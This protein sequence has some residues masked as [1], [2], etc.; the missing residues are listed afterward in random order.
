MFFI[1]QFLVRRKEEAKPISNHI[2]MQGT[3][4]AYLLQR[5]TGIAQTYG[6]EG[7]STAVHFITGYPDTLKQ[8]IGD[9]F[10][11]NA[12]SYAI[13]YDGDL[14]LYAP[15]EA[16]WNFALSTIEFLLRDGE[17]G[18]LTLFDYPD[19]ETRGYRVFLPHKDD[20]ETFRHV[21]DFLVQYKYNTIML[22]IG[23]AMEYKR[24]PEINA[25]WVEFCKDMKR[26]SGR[27]HEIQHKTYPW[28]KNAIHVDNGG[29]DYLTQEQVKELVSYCRERFLEVI[30]E[31]PT[32]SH[33]DYLLLAHPELRERDNDDYADTYCPSN[34]ESYKL[35]FDVLDE[36]IDVMQPKRINIGHDEAYTFSI[37][38]T[39]KDQIPYKLYAQDIIKIHEYLNQKGIA[40]MM[41][42]EK[43][44]DAKN[45]SG[46]SIGGG[47][48]KVK[49]PETGME[50]IYI[51]GLSDCASLLPKDITMMHWYH[52]FDENYDHVYHK[53]GYPMVYGNL[54]IFS[55]TNWR[56]RKNWG[57]KG[58]F[59]S[60]WGSFHPEYMQRNTQSMR[61][62]FS[63]KVMWSD[64][65]DHTMLDEYYRENAVETFYHFNP[66]MKDVTPGDNTQARVV[67][68]THA[69]ELDIP[70]KPFYDGI[71]IEDSVYVM[72][73]YVLSYEDGTSA[74]LSVKFGTNITNIN[75]KFSCQDAHCNEMI[76]GGNPVL[77]GDTLYFT[78]VYQNPH[79]EK[80]ITGF[81]YQPIKP[82]AIRVAK[83]Q[84]WK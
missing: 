24:H 61:L 7:D 18:P 34:P 35:V 1:P 13:R 83:V 21:V 40:T 82:D 5:V 79:P 45:T 78:A 74:L 54:N 22:E 69:T 29:G 27:T 3:D 32:L 81:S 55:M 60:N 6:Q 23:G 52:V 77:M 47:E 58:G 72:G 16:G 17:M 59:V 44:L 46:V 53:N 76:G 64:E 67:A 31:V 65:F 30:P 71:F 63:A 49:D 11:D 43:L 38:D 12:E 70:F 10:A 2:H 51:H 20:F 26:Y 50:V 48:R 15:T 80:A 62:I 19:C 66:F 56:K 42:G 75:T 84:F 8:E 37:C 25:S 68:V 41:W 14:F 36:V 9:K 73:H 33:C 57:A 28:A 39:C 4:N